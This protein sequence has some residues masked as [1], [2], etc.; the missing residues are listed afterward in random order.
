MPPPP[1]RVSEQ[2]DTAKKPS[3]R[4]GF[5][6]R[7]PL[8]LSPE[9]ATGPQTA[10]NQAV[11]RLFHAGA[12][13]AKL[14]ISQ[15]GDPDELEADRIAEQVMRMPEAGGAIPCATCAAGDQPCLK[16]SGTPKIQRTAR[17][18][19]GGIAVSENPLR[20]LGSGQPLDRSTRSFFEPRLGTDLSHVR[21][22]TD[23]SAAESA[24][25]IQ[26]RAF[27]AG[28]NVV[29]GAGEY[30]PD[31]QE[32]KRL[33]AHELAHTIQQGAGSHARYQ[34]NR[35]NRKDDTG[36]PIT[37]LSVNIQ[38]QSQATEAPLLDRY[39]A[40]L[41]VG[42]WTEAAVLLNGFND[43]DIQVRINNTTELPPTSRLKLR[44]Y[45]PEWAFRVRRPLLIRDYEDAKATGQWAEA[46]KWLNGFSDTDIQ[47][48]ASQLTAGE[49]GPMLHGAREA[50]EGVSLNRVLR[51]IAHRYD[52]VSP[53]PPGT[54]VLTVVGLMKVAGMSVQVAS[55]YVQLK[56]GVRVAPSATDGH[57]GD[58]QKSADSTD[59]VNTFA[60]A[61]MSSG[62]I[63]MVG[64]AGAPQR[65]QP[66]QL[67]KGNLAHALIGDT[68]C[69]LNQPS[70]S[71]LSVIDILGF[72]KGQV[73]GLAKAIKAAHADLF[74][75]LDMRPD[76]T[77][78]GKQQIF[79]IKPVGSTALA[80]SE[81]LLYIE[82]FDSLDIPG[83]SFTLGQ[84]DNRGTGGIIPGPNGALVW[85]SP[86]PGAIVYY[87][88]EP[89]EN[90]RYVRERI[91]NGAYEPGL[92]LGP[93]AII[94][95]GLAGVA[96]ARFVVAPM[97]VATYESLI[98][99]L[100]SAARAAGQHIPRVIGP[101]LQ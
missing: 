59:D 29:F 34:T 63:A 2:A 93:E 40:A 5:P 51:G 52:E 67:E 92:R 83:L 37:Q 12:I 86:L 76:I 30:N 31:G 7:D 57:V 73:P 28:R 42:N 47:L 24:R 56:L 46:A 69:P 10:G 72:A 55:A 41:S 97:A 9:H 101:Q 25:T 71:D 27:T 11:Q 100:V 64:G 70:V 21:I 81:A 54:K 17:D 35:V 62:S 58:Q 13:Q 53:D 14:G 15:P 4:G 33:L 89:P 38:R 32:G 65:L 3:L 90:P 68:Y 43:A 77:D 8:N 78:L 1:M 95:M 19:S 96:V 80:V 74:T 98:P 45:T 49:V 61:M 23:N 66:P 6:D 50:M 94:A 18:S 36:S 44:F 39:R 75:N 60:A 26:A 84:P 91:E 16:C 22:H 79:E 48:L 88:V 85:G 82:L 20:H 99:I 87:F